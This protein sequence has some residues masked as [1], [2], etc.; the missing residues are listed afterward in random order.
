MFG[1]RVAACSAALLLLGVAPSGSTAAKIAHASLAAPPAIS[2][3][4]TFFDMDAK[5]KMLVLRKGT[6]GFSCYVGGPGVGN[7]PFCADG[8]AM[9]W[10]GDW[11]AH[12]P[13]PTIGK[14]GIMYMFLGGTDWSATDP[15]ATKGKPI[16]EPPHWM[17]MYPY[18]GASGIPTG[19]KNT[20]TWIMWAGTPYAHLMINQRP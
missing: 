10:V 5:G 8:P 6:N 2:A 3:N 20:G 1:T 12:K 4:A 18:T 16:H 11:L 19:E 9:Q 15:W 17:I 7:D 13:A 14:P